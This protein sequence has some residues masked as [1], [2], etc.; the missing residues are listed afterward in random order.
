MLLL[1]CAGFYRFV[2]W[3]CENKQPWAKQKGAQAGAAL[4]AAALLPPRWCQSPG[5]PGWG[6]R[7][8]ARRT[9]DEGGGSVPAPAV[10]DCLSAI[11]FLVAGTASLTPHVSPT[12]WS[13]PGLIHGQ[14]N[15]ILPARLE[16][17]SR[18]HVAAAALPGAYGLEKEVLCKRCLI[19]MSCEAQPHSKGTLLECVQ[20]CNPL[21]SLSHRSMLFL[22]FNFLDTF[23]R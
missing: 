19:A 17:L 22:P 23:R 18:G 1:S 10:V 14:Q 13:N 3:R 20:D 9:W 8:G 6:L 11:P 5:E 2:R 16:T 4:A 21:S 12:S 15:S 7:D